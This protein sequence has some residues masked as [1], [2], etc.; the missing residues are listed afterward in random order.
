MPLELFPRPI[1]FGRRPST[2]DLVFE[3]I[4]R[5]VVELKLTPGTKV[6]ELDVARS[7]GVS[8]QPVRDAFYRLSQLGFLTI[9]PQKATEVSRISKSAVLQA[10]F[11][12]TALE[13]ETVRAAAQ[14]VGSEALLSVLDANLADQEEAAAAGDRERF[15][16]LDDAFHKTICSQSGNDFAWSLISANKAHMDR[17]RYLSLAFSAGSALDDHKLIAAALSN[18]NC[19]AAADCMRVHLGRILDILDRISAEHPEYFAE[20]RR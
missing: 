2:T 12:R 16:A 15:H 4:Y 14:G 3:E 10:R 13:V 5:Q 9:R 1:D 6:S 20:D 17:V 11:I 7:L 8:R 18:H 19:E